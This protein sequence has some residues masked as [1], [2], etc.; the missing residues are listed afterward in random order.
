MGAHLQQARANRALAEHLLQTRANDPT[1][2]QWAAT[3]AFY[4]AVHCIEARLATRNVHSRDHTQRWQAM[5]DPHNSVRQDVRR[6]YRY[7]R[8]AS[9]NARYRCANFTSEYVRTVILDRFLK[10]VTDWTGI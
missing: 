5:L 1:A 6:A 4:C 10:R 9:E 7:L 2:L 3:V 8:D